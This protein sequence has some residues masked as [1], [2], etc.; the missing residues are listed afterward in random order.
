MAVAAW[1]GAYDMRVANAFGFENKLGGAL[2]TLTKALVSGPSMDEREAYRA[3]AEYR[4][5]QAGKVAAEAALNRQEFDGGSQL[6]SIFRQ[7]PKM[8]ADMTAPVIDPGVAGPARAMAAS[9]AEDTR[10]GAREFMASAPAELAAAAALRGGTMPQNIGSLYRMFLANTPGTSDADVGRAVVGSGD[11]IGV[12]DAVSLADRNG[13]AG[14]NA[15]SSAAEA[16]KVEG[17]HSRDRRRGQDINSSDR[18]FG[19]NV[20]SADRLALGEIASNDRQRGQ[21]MTA[22]AAAARIAATAAKPG[23]IQKVSPTDYNNFKKMLLSSTGMQFEPEAEAA[24]VDR[25]SEIFQENKNAP[26]AMQQA[27]AEFKD[28]MERTDSAWWG[29]SEKKMGLKS[30]VAGAVTGG[31]TPR[32]EEPSPAAGVPPVE[33]R[34]PNKVYQTP[35]GPMMWTGTGW[36]P[37]A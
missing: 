34:V 30:P 17:V 23:S 32:P 12:N 4:S 20:S 14:R 29:L 16:M 37:V 3:L 22:E 5:A 25:A 11:E 18:R 10:G 6:A 35:K 2:S 8:R 27:L 19:V 7:M 33:S 21:D 26:N 1:S 28:K 36:V 15:A 13:V 9:A 24:I 31:E